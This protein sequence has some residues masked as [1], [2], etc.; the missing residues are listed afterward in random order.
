[1]QEQVQVLA[2]SEVALI[3]LG[4]I[5]IELRTALRVERAVERKVDKVLPLGGLPSWQLVKRGLYSGSTDLYGITWRGVR[6][7]GGFFIFWFCCFICFS[8]LVSLLL[9]SPFLARRRPRC[10][11]DLCSEAIGVIGVAEDRVEDRAEDRAED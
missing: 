3:V 11:M 4:C 6:M 1:M 8:C 9:P 7:R 2:A 5:A 10:L